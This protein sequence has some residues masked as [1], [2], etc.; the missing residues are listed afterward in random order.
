MSHQLFANYHFNERLALQL[1]IPLIHRSFQRI[2]DESLQSGNEAGLGDILLVGYYVPFQRKNPY[3]QFNWKLIGGL[4]FP[5]GNSDP[6]AEELTEDDHHEEGGEEELP[7]IARA[8]RSHHEEEASG[9]HGHDIALGSGSW[10]ML[11]GSNIFGGNN[12]WFYTGNI[13]YTIRTRGDFDY[14]Y[15]NDLLWYGG[16]GYYVSTSQEWPV[17]LQ[18]LLTGEHKGEDHLGEENREAGDTAL[19][20]VYMGPMAIIGI[21]QIATVEAGVGFPLM[22]DNSGLQTVPKYRL[23]FGIT[24]MFQ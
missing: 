8:F 10:D 7:H 5:T 21:K 4:K 24:W 17:G 1:N 11:I 15:A 3:S 16:P 2:E 13:Q 6:L 18:A 9:V 14:Q 23:R 22:I 12:K 19:T 20:S